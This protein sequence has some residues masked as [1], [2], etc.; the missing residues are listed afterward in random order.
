MGEASIVANLLGQQRM[1]VNFDNM[2]HQS[3]KRRGFIQCP[4]H[5]GH[6]NCR[7]YVFVQDF[8]SKRHCT[9]YLVAWACA[10]Y[11]EGLTDSKKHVKE[12]PSPEAVALVHQEMYPDD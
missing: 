3:G 10:A 4:N 5:E 8:A 9:S 7:L 12:K 11:K 1:V 6:G 2:S